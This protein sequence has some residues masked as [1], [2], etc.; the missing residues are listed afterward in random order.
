MSSK[1]PPLN[2]RHYTKFN[3]IDDKLANFL[4]QQ[5][6][7]NHKERSLLFLDQ[8]TGKSI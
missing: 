5:D 3:L 1:L 2:T 4:M 8:N 6:G 7:R